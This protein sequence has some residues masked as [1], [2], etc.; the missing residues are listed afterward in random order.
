MQGLFIKKIEEMV[1][2]LNFWVEENKIIMIY[3]TKTKLRP[4]MSIYKQF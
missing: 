1:Y 3:Q 2:K 4:V